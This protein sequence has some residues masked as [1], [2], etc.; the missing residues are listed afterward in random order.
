MAM[1]LSG[2][3]H[4]LTHTFASVGDWYL[5][6]EEDA[7]PGELAISY[8]FHAGRRIL[9]YNQEVSLICGGY[10]INLWA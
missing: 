9:S 6:V 10:G 7:K 2:Q 8:I 1:C 3:F 4:T 5:G